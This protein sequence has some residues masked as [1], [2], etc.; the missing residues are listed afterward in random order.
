MNYCD[1]SAVKQI[2]QIN[3]FFLRQ[4]LL[5]L[6]E[7]GHNAGRRHAAFRLIRAYYLWYEDD[8]EP[9]GWSNPIRKVKA[10]KVPIEPLKPVSFETGNHMVMVKVCPHNTF[11]GDRDAAILLCLLDTG[12]RASELLNIDLEDLNQASGTILIL[13]G[14]GGKPLEVYLGKHSRKLLRKYLKHRIDDS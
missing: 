1:A 6:E 11:I 4:Y 10:P 13:K 12:A 3:P 2:G 14:K 9:E 7:S 8:V 5:N